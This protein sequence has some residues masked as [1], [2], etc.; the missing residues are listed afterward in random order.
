MVGEQAFYFSLL[1][2]NLFSNPFTVSIGP[3]WLF[4]GVKLTTHVHVI[5]RLKMRGALP[6][7]CNVSSL[8]DAQL[9]MGAI[10]VYC[11]T[12]NDM[13]AVKFS[14]SCVMIL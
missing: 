12:S 14:L 3:C 9:G 6:V 11:P 7:P 4:E 5:P 13:G 8:H 1:C 10:Y 2:P